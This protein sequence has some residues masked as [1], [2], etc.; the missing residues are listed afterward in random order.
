MSA[1]RRVPLTPLAYYHKNLVM[2]RHPKGSGAFAKLS[3]L[4][5]DSTTE[6]IMHL[7]A[8]S[9]P[10][11][12]KV[13]GATPGFPSRLY[14]WL[15]PWDVTPPPG[16]GAP[17]VRDTFGGLP[18]KGTAASNSTPQPNV[19]FSGKDLI[20]RLLDHFNAANPVPSN[21]AFEDAANAI[22]ESPSYYSSFQESVD[23]FL[24]LILSRLVPSRTPDM[25]SMSPGEGGSER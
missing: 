25:P 1:I 23:A 21:K 18:P 15:R 2:L 16:G 4:P 8:L 6:K 3:Y 19:D 10:A 14:G 9:S 22:R 5:P 13:I 20:N 17:A 11:V 24:K 7:Y 12:L